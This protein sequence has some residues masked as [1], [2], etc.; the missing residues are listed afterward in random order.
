MPYRITGQERRAKKKELSLLRRYI[1]TFWDC[2]Q[3]NDDMCHCYGHQNPMS[4]EEAERIYNE[5]VERASV[6]ERILSEEV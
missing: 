6:S 4:R 5:A 3:L 1:R 2:W